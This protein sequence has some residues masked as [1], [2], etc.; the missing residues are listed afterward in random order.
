M[1][2]MCVFVYVHDVLLS[3]SVHV[4]MSIYVSKHVSMCVFLCVYM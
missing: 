3:A 1:T 4:F 2:I